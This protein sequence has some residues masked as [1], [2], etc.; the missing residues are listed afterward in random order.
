MAS[1]DL[2]ISDTLSNE[3][4][5]VM[6]ALDTKF[7]ARNGKPFT[8]S[9]DMGNVSYAVPSFHGS[10]DIAVRDGA[11]LHQEPFAEAA[12]SPEAFDIAINCAKGLAPSR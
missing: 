8:A 10:F 9:T 12:A 1:E 5:K 2:R 7:I 11:M 6:A 4:T 3:F